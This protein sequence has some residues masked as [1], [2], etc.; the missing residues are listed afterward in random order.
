MNWQKPAT[1]DPNGELRSRLRAMPTA[2]ALWSARYP[3]LPGILQDDPGVPKRNVYAGNIS[4][5]GRWDDVTPA[6]RRFQTVTNNL[7]FDNDRDW[8]RLI[9]DEAGRPVR[10][11][12]KDAAAV[13][14]LGFTVP[15]VERMGLCQDERR[16]SWPVRH[17]T[18]PVQL[19][20][21]SKPKSAKP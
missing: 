12:F 17:V 11:E 8:A 18:R 10:V 19:P 15:P 9:K 16:A 13:H 20:D 14:S 6:I 7:V 1:D 2:N 3:T 4:A 5:G 21:S